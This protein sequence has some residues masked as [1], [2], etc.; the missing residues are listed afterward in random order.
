M[1][2]R[3]LAPRSSEVGFVVSSSTVYQH[4]SLDL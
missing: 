2:F 1:Q 4:F 3:Q